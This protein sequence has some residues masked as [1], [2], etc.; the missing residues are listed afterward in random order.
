MLSE[1]RSGEGLAAGSSIAD[2]LTLIAARRLG[3]ASSCLPS[4][5]RRAPRSGGSSGS[6]S[7]AR[8]R[9]QT[10]AELSGGNQQKVALARLLHHDV[11]VLVLDEPT[12]GIDVASKAQIYALIDELVSAGDR[13]R[14]QGRAAGQQLSPGAARRLRSHRGHVAR[15]ARTGR[16]RSTEWT[17]HALLMDASG[18][19]RGLVSARRLLDER[20]V[21]VGLV[22]R[23]R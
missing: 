10:V 4:R 11:D 5:Q 16:A 13:G 8:G 21:L 2:N 15:P 7:D 12:R 17:E 1:D 19:Q 23:R 3:P 20:G 14:A 6:A 9:A 22:A 18:A